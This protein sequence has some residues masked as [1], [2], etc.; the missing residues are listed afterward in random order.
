MDDGLSNIIMVGEMSGM[1][2][3]SGT[4]LQVSPNCAGGWAGPGTDTRQAFTN[5]KWDLSALTTSFDQHYTHGLTTVR[6]ALNTR[7]AATNSSNNSYMVNLILNSNHP[8]VVHVGMADGSVVAMQ[9][10][11]DIATLLRLCWI[12]DGQMVSME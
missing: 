11:L 9:E 3:V 4:S 5:G 10:N 2:S 8:Q 12:K 7:T 6:Y 1:V